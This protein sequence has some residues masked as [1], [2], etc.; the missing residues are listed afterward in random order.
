MN[1]SV[2]ASQLLQDSSPSL[3]APS[4]YSQ[5]VRFYPAHLVV[6][7]LAQLARRGVPAQLAL[8]GSGIGEAEM[9]VA[10]TRFSV[11]QI[12]AVIRNAI[13]HAPGVAL[14]VGTCFNTSA[15]GIFGF[16][17]LSSPSRKALLQTVLRYNRLIDPL[18]SLRYAGRDGWAVWEIEPSL[19]CAPT[20]PL[21]RFV[22]ELKMSCFK[23]MGRDLYGG[24]FELKSISV[25]FP[26]PPHADEYKDIFNCDI[27]FNQER[28]E[29]VFREI[30][31]KARPEA[32]A[33]T[34]AMMLELCEQ[35]LQKM[36][37]NATAAGAVLMILL[38][39]SGVFPNIDEVARE[40]AVNAR[41]LRRRLEA[42]GTSYS[43]ILSRH[44]MQLALS[45]LRTSELNNNEIAARLGYSDATNFRRAFVS[46]AGAPPSH[47]RPSH[48]A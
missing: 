41:T 5:G 24:D 25:R 1:Q 15:C 12:M 14:Q 28:N 20:D 7:L 3:V 6:F 4:P 33:I 26:A 30:T 29:I 38:G 9:R 37:R 10:A 23:A 45:Y 36:T 35:A 22:V 2:N 47:F 19:A 46:W 18:T 16:A 32:D 31:N 39:C 21:Y 34:H 42:E 44:R 17:L 8:A 13:R 48:L 11:L 40:L 43:E 27:S